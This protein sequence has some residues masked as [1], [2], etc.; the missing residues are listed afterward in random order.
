MKKIEAIIRSEK[1][2][3]VKTALFEA[4]I[5][6]ITVYDVKGKGHQKNLMLQFR[7]KKIKID[8]LPKTKIELFVRNSD[9]DKIVDI[10]VKNARTENIGDGKIIILPIENMIRIRTGEEG[11]DAI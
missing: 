8:L 6:G 3:D 11:T 2:I 4:N 5:E 9:V 10:I 1:L 7:G